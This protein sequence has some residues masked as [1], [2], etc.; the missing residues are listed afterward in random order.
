M[1][2]KV[3]FLLMKFEFDYRLEKM[4]IINKFLNKEFPVRNRHIFKVC[5]SVVYF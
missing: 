2:L 3:L 4:I 5:I 1:W